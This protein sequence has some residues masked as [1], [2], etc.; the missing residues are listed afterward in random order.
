MLRIDS[1]DQL[2]Q[3]FKN[4]PH[5][6]VLTAGTFDGLHRAH[7]HLIRM[8]RERAEGGSA[9]VFTFSNH[10]L[11]IL[12]PPYQPKALLTPQ[13]KEEILRQMDVDNLINPPFTRQF[14]AMDAE[15]FAR[16]ILVDALDIDELVVGF[17]FRFGNQGLGDEERLRQLGEKYGFDVDIQAA[18]YHEEWAISSSHIRDLIDSGHL[19]MAA[20]MLGR[21]YEM[22]GPVEH[23]FGRGTKLGFPTANL[24]VDPAYAI[25]ASG[26]YAVFVIVGDKPYKAMMNIGT[27]PTFAGTEHRPEVFL[28]DFDG[29]LYGETLRVQF[30]ERIREERKFESAEALQERL[31]VDEKVCRAVLESWQAQPEVR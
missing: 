30:I 17:D 10:P 5:P 8:T 13:R 20:R 27:S 26:V 4:A 7:Q 18:I 31:K 23:G 12:A 2:P 9:I 16:S 25:P 22:E 24:A 14:A 28:F 21:P 11:S 3:A 1:L 29:D 15:S 6:R 19:R